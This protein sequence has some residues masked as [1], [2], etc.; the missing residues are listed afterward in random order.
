MAF[1]FWRCGTPIARHDGEPT[2]K[3]FRKCIVSA[4][5]CN[6]KAANCI[7]FYQSWE[8]AICV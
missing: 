8:N 1:S 4:I 5:S 6:R 7:L 2:F 3:D